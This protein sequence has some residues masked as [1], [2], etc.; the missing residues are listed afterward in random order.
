M[1]Q[2]MSQWKNAFHREIKISYYAKRSLHTHVLGKE[3]ENSIYQCFRGGKNLW[4]GEH[5]FVY[6]S[7]RGPMSVHD[8]LTLHTCHSQVRLLS[9]LRAP[10]T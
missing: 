8:I 2:L 1:A 10:E 6:I 3:Y 4:N 5:V 9:G 7:I